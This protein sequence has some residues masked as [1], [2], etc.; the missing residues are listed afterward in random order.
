MDDMDHIQD[1]I[2]AREDALLAE[3]RRK[4]QAENGIKPP[5]HRECD[6]C[7]EDI[8]KKRLQL[9]PLTRYCVDCQ[10]DLEGTR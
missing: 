3:R 5:E 1:L 7:G 6:S 8:P 4:L 2:V 10:N 9:L